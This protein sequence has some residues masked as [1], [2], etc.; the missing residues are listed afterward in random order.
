[1]ARDEGRLAVAWGFHRQGHSAS[2][3]A[4]TDLFSGNSLANN[5]IRKLYT[6][7]TG[8]QVEK[9]AFWQQ[10]KESPER[11]NKIAHSSITVTK[12]EAEAS[13]RAATDLVAH[14][15]K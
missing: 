15:K 12:S 4:V 14:L 8:D 7:L 1:M 6:A 13:H 11:R 10:F 9:A 5:R 3:K 2:G